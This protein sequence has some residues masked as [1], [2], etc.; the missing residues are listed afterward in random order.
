[1]VPRPLHKSKSTDILF[2]LG[3]RKEEEDLLVSF[4]PRRR[5]AVSICQ[6]EISRAQERTKSEVKVRGRVVE[7]EVSVKEGW[8]SK[9]HKGR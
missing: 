2:R 5:A 7:E 4:Q 8:N 6:N 9:I 3:N 1:M